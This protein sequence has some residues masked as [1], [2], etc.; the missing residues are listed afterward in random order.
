MDIVCPNGQIANKRS[1]A[2]AYADV[3]P[4]DAINEVMARYPTA[5]IYPHPLPEGDFTYRIYWWQP[6]AT[7]EDQ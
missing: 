6:T 7:K 4:I 3:N 2:I 5:S 1:A